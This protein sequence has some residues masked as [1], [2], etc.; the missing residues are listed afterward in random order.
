MRRRSLAYALEVTVYAAAILA[1]LMLAVFAYRTDQRMQKEHEY[2]ML[3]SE[4]T[5][6]DHQQA[7]KDHERRMERH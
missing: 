6:K 3:R 4:Q 5:L 1:M 2:F 7:L